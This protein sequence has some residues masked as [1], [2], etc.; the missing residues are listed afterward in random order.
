MFEDP[1]R[2]RAA[3]RFSLR[4]ETEGKGISWNATVCHVTAMAPS[5]PELSTSNLQEMPSLTDTTLTLKVITK[6][7]L[8]DLSV[9]LGLHTNRYAQYNLKNVQLR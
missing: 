3:L 9:L 6:P 4:V 1:P 7:P 8:P 5:C 2:I